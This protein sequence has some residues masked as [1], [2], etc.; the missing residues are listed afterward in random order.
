M[1]E[2]WFQQALCPTLEQRDEVRAVQLQQ[3]RSRIDTGLAK[4]AAA[5]VSTSSAPA[6]SRLPRIDDRS[7]AH[8]KAGYISRHERETVLN[9]RGSNQP[10]RSGERSA[11]FLGFDGYPAP[12]IGGGLGHGQAVRVE[13]SWRSLLKPFL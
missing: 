6:S 13:P 4:L 5:K 9:G 3:L 2:E 1:L 12:A 11:I 8:G 10:V 7:A